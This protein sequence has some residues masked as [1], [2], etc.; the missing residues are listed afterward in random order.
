MKIPI[1]LCFILIQLLDHIAYDKL[2]YYPNDNFKFKPN[3]IHKISKIN[4]KLALKIIQLQKML[5]ILNAFFS[6]LSNDQKKIIKMCV[7]WKKVE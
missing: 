2:F 6:F 5:F 1:I 3:I 7:Y 4:Y